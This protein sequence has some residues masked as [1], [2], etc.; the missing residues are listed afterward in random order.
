IGTK[1]YTT[2]ADIKCNYKVTI[3]VQKAGTKEIVTAKDAAGNVSVA[4]SVIVI[5][6]TAPYSI[7][8]LNVNLHH[9]DNPLSQLHLLRC[10]WQLFLFRYYALKSIR[11]V[12]YSCAIVKYQ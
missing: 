2:K 7:P 6:K 12:M 10:L 4:K 1:K 11:K 5:D 8:R 3:P 9:S